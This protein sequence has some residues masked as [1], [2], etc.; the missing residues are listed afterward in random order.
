ME[1]DKSL[2]TYLKTS[3]FQFDACWVVLEKALM[4][5]F[6]CFHEGWDIK[7]QNTMYECGVRDYGWGL[8]TNTLLPRTYILGE[9]L[10]EDNFKKGIDRSHCL[11]CSLLVAQEKQDVLVVTPTYLNTHMNYFRRSKYG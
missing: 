7:S 6:Q 3:P 2:F 8:L 4:T 9:A 5:D 1:I 11:H 10:L